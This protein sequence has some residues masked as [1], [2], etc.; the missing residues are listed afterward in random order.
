MSSLNEC[1]RAWRFVDSRLTKC[2]DHH[3]VDPKDYDWVTI[4]LA[5]AAVTNSAQ[6]QG[7][8]ANMTIEEFRQGEWASDIFS[9]RVREHKTA[10]T[11][12]A[13]VLLNKGLHQRVNRYVFYLR[14]LT[15]TA[16]GF[17]GAEFL[18]GA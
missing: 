8:V 10:S 11:G 13:M 17:L 2:K 14:P 3:S 6:R 9:I 16:T 4:I 18:G 5:Y 15:Q 1:D 12:S 7:A